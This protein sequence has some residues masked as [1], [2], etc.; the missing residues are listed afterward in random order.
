MD[1]GRNIVPQQGTVAI[2]LLVLLLLLLLL[3]LLFPRLA[4]QSLPARLC[5]PGL[6]SAVVTSMT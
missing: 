6:H 5:S 1:L 4:C 3:L 2:G